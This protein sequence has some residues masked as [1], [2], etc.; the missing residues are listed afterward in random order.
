[1]VKEDSRK[2]CSLFDERS[3]KCRTSSGLKGWHLFGARDPT[4]SHPAKVLTSHC[5]DALAVAKL[6]ACCHCGPPLN[7]GLNTCRQWLGV[8]S[9]IG[10]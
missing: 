1:M 4:T 5:H 3:V 10:S 6:R 7:D 2:S 9:N 8:S